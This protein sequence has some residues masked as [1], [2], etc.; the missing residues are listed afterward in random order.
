MEL[1]Q[2]EA[3]VTAPE[4]ESTAAPDAVIT[5]TPEEQEPRTFTQEEL[6]KIVAKEKAKERRK[7]ERDLREELAQQRQAPIEAPQPN[8]FTSAEDYVEALSDYKTEQKLAEREAQQQRK[9]VESGYEDRA[10]EARA[11]YAD[12]DEV[13]HGSHVRITPEMA[14]VIKASEV[15]PEVAYHLGKNPDEAARIAR[16]SPLV[17]AREIGKIEATLV[18]NA[19]VVKKS[20]SAPEP[21]RPLG[22][23]ST[24]PTVSTSDPRSTK[25]S[26]S[27]WIKQRNAEILKRS[28]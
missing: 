10:D 5:Q 27:D 15:G 24:V 21:I 26:D 22:S 9:Q 8:Q 1:N 11:K 2:N 25:L 17:Q 4:S 19:P 7:V 23:R 13:A 12:Y 6:D 20:S 14:E 18:P 16:L 3:V 28:T